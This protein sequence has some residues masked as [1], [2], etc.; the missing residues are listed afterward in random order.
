[1]EKHFFLLFFR[2]VCGACE[3]CQQ[4][5]PQIGKQ[6]AEPEF[7]PVPEDPVTSLAVDFVSLPKSVVNGETYDYLMVVVCRLT[8]YI[9]AIRTQELGL[10]RQ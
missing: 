3:V 4:T 9:L 5:K 1:M 7:Y 2:Q 6:D 10:S 8:G